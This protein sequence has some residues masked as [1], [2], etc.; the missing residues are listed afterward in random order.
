V[1]TLPLRRR[2]F[3]LVAAA[4]LPV[5]AVSGFALYQFVEQKRI[6]A[7]HA[8]VEICRALMTAVDAELE[9]SLTLIEAYAHARSLDDGNEELFHRTINEL[10]RRDANWLTIILARPDGTAV[11]DASTPYGQPLPPLVERESFEHLVRSG[12]RTIGYL[13][14]GSAG[15]FAVPLRAPV[16]RGGELRYV[17]TAV[18][19]PDGIRAVVDRQHLASDW[20]VSVFDAKGQRVARSRRHEESLGKPGAPS[21]QELMRSGGNEGTGLTRTL[22]GEPVYTAY[23]RSPMSGWSVAI[24]IPP[25]VVDAGARQSFLAYGTGILLSIALGVVAAIAIGRGIA[26]PI[27]EL[28]GAAEALGR[29]QPFAP[30]Q[31][32]IAEIRQVGE[33]LSSAASERARGEAE[34]EALLSRERDARA[35][36]EAASRAKGEFLAL[37]GHELRN[38]LGAIANAARLLEHPDLGADEAARARAI[39]GRQS[40]HLARLTDDLLDAGRAIMGKIVL[41]RRPIDLAMAVAQ[42]LATLRGS[43]R[44][45]HHHVVEDL[46]EVWTDADPTRVEQIVAN[47]VGN[48][49]KYTPAGGTVSVRV[50]REASDAVLRVA[51]DGIGM[52]RE[53]LDRVF[54]PFVQGEAG[55]DR[56]AGGLGLGLTLVRR[57][58]LLHGGSA[59]AASDGP[60]RGTEVTVRMPAVAPL[61]QEP[62]TVGLDGARGA[63]RDVLLVEDNAD[64]RESLRRLLELDGHRVR[65]AADGPAALALARAALPEVAL[66]DLGLPTMDGFEVARRMRAEFGAHS[67]PLLIA[68]TGYGQAQ[69]RRRSAEAGF[70]LHLVKPVDYGKLAQV[71]REREVRRA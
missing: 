47:L 12:T 41:E 21:L 2:L 1:R 66:V 25:A 6:A 43:G 24:G 23:S 69:D 63:R 22:E 26:R 48:A 28:R 31:T 68:L 39:I 58:A 70:D 60:G 50:G 46:R 30:P 54:E 27:D 56:A 17:L 53:L 14:R 13:A 18:V 4:I 5:T 62:P 10:L 19:K 33:A 8:G 61:P 29:Q 57:L 71:L 37:L 45:A 15:A 67:V 64:A 32:T 9:R 34:R 36:A 16:V 42:A 59:A 7:Q 65:T 38:P 49:V 44:L 55:L 40:E 35:A 51:D 52:S 3:L 20:V 11:V